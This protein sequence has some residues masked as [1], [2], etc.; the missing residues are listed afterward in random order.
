MQMAEVIIE[1]VNLLEEIR[2]SEAK[3]NEVIKTVEEIK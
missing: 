1:G 3:D 2:K